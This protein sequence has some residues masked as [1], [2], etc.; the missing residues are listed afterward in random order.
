MAQ[1]LRSVVDLTTGAMA[2]RLHGSDVDKFA[3]VLPRSA[4]AKQTISTPPNKIK[5][6]MLIMYA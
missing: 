5:E 2:S 4:P 3:C 6:S 1:Q